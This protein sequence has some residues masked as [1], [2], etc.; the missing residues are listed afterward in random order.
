MSSNSKSSFDERDVAEVKKAIATGQTKETNASP[1]IYLIHL[2]SL[3]ES[4]EYADSSANRL[5]LPGFH[6]NDR[7]E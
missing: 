4:H 2:N 3:L 5:L 6:F 7:S 1:G